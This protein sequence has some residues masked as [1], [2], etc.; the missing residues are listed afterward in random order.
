MSRHV[1]ETIWKA[2]STDQRH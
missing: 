2:R 1:T